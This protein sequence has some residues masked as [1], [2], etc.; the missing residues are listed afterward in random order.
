MRRYVLTR[1]VPEDCVDAMIQE[2]NAQPLVVSI[3]ED[4]VVVYVGDMV[5]LVL[6]VT[7]EKDA[8]T[9]NMVDQGALFMLVSMDIAIVI[10]V[11]M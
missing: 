6:V 7:P 2:K 3:N 4:S 11:E 10:G 8:N 1:L 5:M 9:S